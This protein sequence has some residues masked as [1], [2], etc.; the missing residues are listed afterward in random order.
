M[1]EASSLLILS[2]VSSATA[3][4]YSGL[5]RTFKGFCQTLNLIAVPAEEATL[6]NFLTYLKLGRNL[7]PTTIRGYLSAIRHLHVINGV[8][9]PLLNRPRLSLVRAA[10]TKGGAISPARTPISFETLHAIHAK[11]ILAPS[12]EATLFTACCFVAFFGFLRVSEFAAADRPSSKAGLL[13]EHVSFSSQWVQLLLLDTKA[14]R[15]KKGV[16]VVIAKRATNPCAVRWLAAYCRARPTTAEA[17]PLF[18]TEDGSP[19]RQSW[20]RVRLKRMVESLGLPGVFNTHSLRI[21]AATEA[22]A[23]GFSGHEIQK[24]GRWA[25]RA[26]LTYI[27]PSAKAQANLNLRFSLPLTRPDKKTPAKK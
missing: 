9:D 5:Q 7:G 19:M 22:A 20:F 12:Y 11:A 14:D 4:K 23:A 25:S 27:R 24:L 18:V 1:R 17:F 26:F 8:P 13:A 6:V 21:G 15:E 3:R 16:R 10:A 2:S